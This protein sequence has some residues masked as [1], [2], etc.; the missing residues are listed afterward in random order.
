MNN[1]TLSIQVS[2]DGFS[3]YIEN[4]AD[5]RVLDKSGILFMQRS[6]PEE[7]LTQIDSFLKEKG[8]LARKFK[9]VKVTYYNELHTLVPVAFFDEERLPDYLKYNTKIL[10][11]DYCAYDTIGDSGPINVYVPFTNINNYFFEHFGSFDYYHG[12]STLTE[13]ILNK[14]QSKEGGLQMTVQVLPSFFSLIITDGSKVILANTFP[15]E[16]PSDFLYNLLFCALQENID[17]NTVPLNIL[18]D[19]SEEDDRYKLAYTYIRNV[20]IDEDPIFNLLSFEK[21]STR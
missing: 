19:I 9:K 16:S 14:N 2:L 6:T 21:S 7:T 11:T 20:E 5:C 3:F 12:I 10:S 17:L 8:V 1:D 4:D 15:Y 13:S 18:G